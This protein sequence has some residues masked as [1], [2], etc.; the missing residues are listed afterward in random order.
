MELNQI[1]ILFLFIAFHFTLNYEERIDCFSS[2]S[3]RPRENNFYY[4]FEKADLQEDKDAYF[5]FQFY[6]SWNEA[7]IQMVI[8]DE[9]QNETKIENITD[10]NSG[11][12]S[13]KL[14]NLE[15]QK[16]TID[17][18]SDRWVDMIFIDNTREIN[19][20]LPMFI[21]F[22]FSTNFYEDKPPF[23]LI[24]N[25]DTVKE[26]IFYNFI[27]LSKD[28]IS[29][30]EHLLEYCIIDE[31]ECKYKGIEK[32]LNF[33]KG[34]KYKIRLNSYKNDDNLFYFETFYVWKEI[35]FGLLSYE[36]SINEKTCFFLIN[37]QNLKNFYVY[38]DGTINFYSFL[39]EKEKE[40]FPDNLNNLKFIDYG[41]IRPQK[42]DNINE[43]DF[44]LLEIRHSYKYSNL[45]S[46]FNAYYV[47]GP[48]KS[49]E[50]ETGNKAGIFIEKPSYSYDSELYI[51]I[52][53]NKNMQLSTYTPGNYSNI[54][55]ISSNFNG[56]IYMN[57]T[58]EKTKIKCYE[59][60][61][62]INDYKFQ[63]NFVT[64]NDLNYFF[65]N[66]GPD[67]L[68]M[69]T[70]SISSSNK[71]NSTYLFGMEEKYYLYIKKY[72]GNMN[73]YKNNKD[74]NLF[75]DFTQF[76]SIPKS[77]EDSDKYK[78]INNGLLIID[79]FHL[80]SYYM[81]YNCLFDLY[82]QKVEDLE[83][84]SI[85]PKMFRFNNLV[86][87]LNENKKYYLN[88][89]VDHLIKLDNNFIEAK[90]LFIDGTGKEFTLDKSNKVINDL[91]GD[92]VTVTSSKNALIYFYKRI[93]NYNKSGVVIFDKEKKRKNMMFNVTNLKNTDSSI[94]IVKDFGFEGYYPMLSVKSWIYIKND[95]FY[96]KKNITIYVEN[97]FDQ[98]DYE[99]Y[100]KEGEKYL[101]YIFD[102][103]E[104]GF[105]IFNTEKYNINN[106][107][108]IDN[109]ITPNNKFNFEMIPP[110]STGSII[111]N[112]IYNSKFKYQ[113][114]SC[115]NEIIKIKVENSNYEFFTN[116]P[117]EK[118]IYNNYYNDLEISLDNE[119]ILS[120]TFKS[121]SEFLF[122]YSSY[123]YDSDRA[124]SERDLTIKWIGKINNNNLQILF[125]HAYET[126]KDQY[127][128]IVAIKDKNNNNESFSDICYLT[129]LMIHNSSSIVIKSF[130]E[131][132]SDQLIYSDVNLS[133]LKIEENTEL[134]IT[135]VCYSIFTERLLKFYTPKEYKF[136]NE[137]EPIEID[138]FEEIIFNSQNRNYFKF[139][140][141]HENENAVKI[142]INVKVYN[143][144]YYFI[145]IGPEKQEI[146]KIEYGG[147]NIQINLEESGIYYIKILEVRDRSQNYADYFYIFATG[148]LIDIID[149]TKKAY[150][151]NMEISFNYKE[152]PNMYRVNNLKNDIYVY[153]DYSLDRYSYDEEIYPNPFEICNKNNECE[154]NIT[155]YKFEK[156]NNYTI[157]I[158]SISKDNRYYYFPS[159]FFFPILENNIKQNELGYFSLSE[160]KLFIFDLKNSVNLNILLLNGQKMYISSSEN[161]IS[162]DNLNQLN[163]EKYEDVNEYIK[164]NNSSGNDYAVIIP[165]PLI[166]NQI[167]TQIIIAT[168]VIKK[169]ELKTHTLPAG[170]CEI[171]DIFEIDYTPYD[172]L[173]SLNKN[174][175]KL[176]KKNENNYE[177]IE[178]KEEENE[179]EKEKEK[180]KENEEEKEE[181][182]VEK[183][184]YLNNYNVLTT[185]SSPVKNLQ[186]IIPIELNK[187]RDF[188]AQNYFSF[189]TYVDKYEKD[190]N[191]T[192]N[193][194][195]PKY[196]FFGAANND[197]FN[198]FISGE[199]SKPLS[200][201]GNY[202]VNLNY[203]F[204]SILRIITD[205]NDFYDFM[206]FYLNNIERKV[207]IYIKE[208]YG[209]N[210]IFE[211]DAD[212]ID[213]NDLSILTRPISTCKG[214]KS[215]L[216]KIY[217]VEGSKLISGYYGLN[218]YYDAYFDF[219]DDN[220]NIEIFEMFKY[221]YYNS[222]KYLKRD[223][224]YN[225]CFTA[226]HLVKLDPNFN[227]EISI[228][229]NK[230]LNIVLN[231]RKCTA[232][233]KGDNL[234]IKA[235]KNAM[236]YF[237]GKL[238]Q[239]F[240]QIK[241]DP[242]QKGKNFEINI[243][244]IS[245]LIL[246]FGFEGYNPMISLGVNNF[247]YE[248]GTIYFENI[249]DKLKTKLV[250]G[251]YLYLYHS[252]YYA[253][254]DEI[255]VNYTS[256]NLNNP[257]ND[258]TF[259]LIPNNSFDDGEEKTLVI[260][261]YHMNY[262]RYQI[263]YCK[264]PHSVKMF[265]K[266]SISN[267]EE[268][269]EFD[270]ETM[271][272][273]QSIDT[274]SFKLRF[275]SEEDF[276]FSYSF[277]D[278][279][280]NI[281]GKSE[282]WY[283]ERKELTNLTIIDIIKKNKN[284]NIL[285]IKFNPNYK[286]SSTR[287]IIVI[288]SKDSHNNNE[289]FSNPCY[290]TKLVTE[291][292]EG[293][294]IL[295]IADT[296]ENDFISINIDISEINS[297]NDEFIMNIISQELRFG[298]MVKYYIPFE[299]N[300]KLI[301]YENNDNDDDND[302]DFPL[303]Y[304][305]LISIG[306]I[307][308]LVIVIFFI[309]RC[310]KRKNQIDFKQ[311]TKTLDNEKLLQEF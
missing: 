295:D 97:I 59:Y 180:E 236:V 158:N 17:I 102:S 140:Y 300:K 56:F 92:N 202:V 12:I 176:E 294:K 138:F 113:F 238:N 87:L 152:N 184:Y 27:E 278:N 20:N 161:K 71:Y 225:I 279:T 240:K 128:I 282:K 136:E 89:T 192:I 94:Y 150:Y 245:I 228:Y 310:V 220:R 265:Y 284:S 253:D 80:F 288:A 237:Y 55:Y 72:N 125:N 51:I 232:E 302:S 107:I 291:K 222:A 199:I 13:F 153:F 160:P 137:K 230:G 277:I 307:L 45:I 305:I 95:I 249:Y 293:I 85:N 171:F 54:L 103:F 231:S 157:Y 108:Y 311:E 129:N 187:K 193:K 52:S 271:I 82:F 130:F 10:I 290:I 186:Y 131:E 244:R 242:K 93:E 26:D 239:Q 215:I 96:N 185:Y 6:E 208:F 261:N 21:F 304:I 181:E 235:S 57:S 162:L 247:I 287:Y 283:K 146:Y 98:S 38:F 133:N 88:F 147:N 11:W 69:R 301:P 276:V 65:N 280:D 47:I 292:V 258:Y 132:S 63:F 30:G 15:P 35:E 275:E 127:Y 119:G 4:K 142:Y 297:K 145:F 170:N 219:D 174:N 76:Q 41:Y 189:P 207:I 120:N 106:I 148:T 167:E 182:K 259:H 46:L 159:Y 262:I 204:P 149:F 3:V 118:Q 306:G 183:D 123:F 83:Y 141:N 79:G 217:T 263:N 74:L 86:K 32:S 211:C 78:V 139:K 264:S 49:L 190:I 285:S 234:K 243:K 5:F 227:A 7:V 151:N 252:Y 179:D 16:Y 268:L 43:N 191:I 221:D 248:P 50:I 2:I 124:Y 224:E 281:F 299:F 73:I 112:S 44:I 61:K 109:L 308:I 270:N 77:Y 197:L 274:K 34:K 111:I 260:N 255:L 196:A 164:L 64:N 194:Y 254:K 23:P 156:G 42:I 218:S 273:Y 296:G 14:T 241:I 117:Y 169:N 100:E 168:N 201:G 206:N 31:N 173:N 256:T 212:S 226:D 70:N 216:N 298:K 289:T 246:D 40:L 33:E 134:I 60:K 39:S 22:N 229:D 67:S 223:I 144:D 28:K 84:I 154:K 166:N 104:N 213:I 257:K 214:K 203:L 126:N 175:N 188:I 198:I 195:L 143:N 309:I 200:S 135:I 251:E 233:I 205:I 272:Y 105:P 177:K 110:N 66:Y 155:I 75:S 81:D 250:E 19:T 58:L 165:I 24:F 209:N 303:K 62:S 68:F 91:K 210:D 286:S 8:K 1:K 99:L 269:I 116:F 163:Y 29:D 172:N 101:I 114:Y 122:V 267:D 37:V 18:T 178:E 121:E 25:I 53:S 36:A 90:V 266:A 115:K 48:Y 9:N